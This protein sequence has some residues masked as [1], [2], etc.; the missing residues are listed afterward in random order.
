MLQFDNI[1]TYYFN[2]IK[3]FFE[4]LLTLSFQ[5]PQSTWHQKVREFSMLVLLALKEYKIQ[6]WDG[7]QHCFYFIQKQ[8]S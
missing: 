2:K 3:Y 7:L 5:P 4:D 8:T 6:G 1:K